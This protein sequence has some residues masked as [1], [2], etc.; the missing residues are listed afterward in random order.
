MP[1]RPIGVFVIFACTLLVAP[2]AADAQPVGKV[3]RI[4]LLVAARTSGYR[5]PWHATAQRGLDEDNSRA[6]SRYWHDLACDRG[7][8]ADAG[9]RQV[10]AFVG[11]QT[12]TALARTSASTP[13]DRV[14]CGMGDRGIEKASGPL[15]GQTDEDEA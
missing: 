9:G 4:G 3:S 13:R 5:V 2:L 7:S 15:P 1:R 11:R 8:G 6:G 10:H 12:L 14:H